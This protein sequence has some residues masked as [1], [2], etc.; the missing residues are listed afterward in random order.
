MRLRQLKSLAGRLDPSRD[1]RW[2]E[3]APEAEAAARRALKLV[4]PT[5]LVPD[6]ASALLCS[7][8][9]A[10]R[11]IR[12]TLL[13]RREVKLSR[14]CEP[15]GTWRPSPACALD[16]RAGSHCASGRPGLSPPSYH[17]C[18]AAPRGRGNVTWPVRHRLRRARN[19]FRQEAGCIKNTPATARAGARDQLGHMKSWS[20][21]RAPLTAGAGSGR[22]R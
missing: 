14:S 9:S 3:S 8:R 2:C 7:P 10:M 16:V 5:D 17:R 18:L 11:V 15:K 6:H 13:Q 12:A 4:E 22:W 1:C 20:C 21:Q 19:P